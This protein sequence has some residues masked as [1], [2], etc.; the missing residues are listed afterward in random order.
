MDIKEFFEVTK[1]FHKYSLFNKVVLIATI[2]FLCYSI[3]LIFFKRPPLYEY[4]VRLELSEYIL[5]ENK[6]TSKLPLQLV[7]FN[8]S[9]PLVQINN[10]TIEYWTL[11]TSILSTPI[12]PDVIDKM[13][14]IRFHRD[15]PILYKNRLI[16]FTIGE[17]TKPA[18]GKSYTIG[19]SFISKE[20]ELKYGG[21]NI[22]NKNGQII[23]EEGNN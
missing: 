14:Y 4:N 10:I 8:E 22:S 18:P 11:K 6:D 12:R 3:Y 5:T 21:W 7:V 13:G 23:I 9:N 1:V 20:I 15:F 19:Y 17:F 16:L 2:I